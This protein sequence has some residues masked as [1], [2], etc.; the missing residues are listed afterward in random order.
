MDK[1]L[2]R[3]GIYDLWG[4]LIPGIIGCVSIKIWLSYLGISLGTG[5]EN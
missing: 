2:D 4:V 1:I 5:L 3:L